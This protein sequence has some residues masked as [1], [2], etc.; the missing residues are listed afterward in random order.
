MTIAQEQNVEPDAHGLSPIELS[1]IMVST[2]RF[3]APGFQMNSVDES[4]F[5]LIPWCCIP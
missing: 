4:C 2:N 3:V 1:K 5:M